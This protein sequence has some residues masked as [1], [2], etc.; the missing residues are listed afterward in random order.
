MVTGSPIKIEPAPSE[1]GGSPVG[2]LPAKNAFERLTQ[3]EKAHE[4]IV[5]TLA[6]IKT[7]PKE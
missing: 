3:L 6:G 2:A 1:G 5:L 7:L 4:P